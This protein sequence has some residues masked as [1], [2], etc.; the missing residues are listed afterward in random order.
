M[1]KIFVFIC[2][3]AVFPLFGETNILVFAGSLR[4]GS[5][6][7]QLAQEAAETARK[8]GAKVTVIDLND[9]PMP[10][11]DADLE[12]KQG[13][14]KNA[15]RLRA[16]MIASDAVII[17]SPEYNS[18]IPAVLKNALDWVSRSEDGGSS[19][20]AYKGK[21]FAIMSAAAGKSGGARGLVHLRSIIEDVGGEVVPFQ[22]TVP[23]AYQPGAMDNSSVV[24]QLQTQLQEVVKR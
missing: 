2:A 19:R 4:A 5:Y 20:D 21:K 1:K 23:S 14:P 3:L 12:A 13:M 7:K 8:L 15:K 11:Y 17:S 22:V 16:L 9:F 24:S 10:F 18:S 6:N